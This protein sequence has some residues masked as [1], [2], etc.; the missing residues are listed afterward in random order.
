MHRGY[1]RDSPCV[2]SQKGTGD[3]PLAELRRFPIERGRSQGILQT[4]QEPSIRGR[5]RGFA[6]YTVSSARQAPA[7]SQESAERHHATQ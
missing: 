6:T 4:D 1:Y 2:F 5:A 7:Y 3:D